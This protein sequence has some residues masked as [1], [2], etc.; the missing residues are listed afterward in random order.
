MKKNR[1]LVV[2][3]AVFL[4]SCVS[5]RKLDFSK[6]QLG[7]TKAEVSQTLR[8]APENMIG[9]KQY[10]DGVMEVQQYHYINSKDIYYWLY[11]WN[12]KLIKYETPELRGKSFTDNGQ[13]SM[14][15]AYES[16]HADQK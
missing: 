15:K 5:F 8:A 14:D 3:L 10:K 12:G 1:F 6:V 2:L 16:M 7:M 13:D 4:F 11:F 9:S